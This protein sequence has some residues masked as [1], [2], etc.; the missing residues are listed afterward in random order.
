MERSPYSSTAARTPENLHRLYTLF[1]PLNRGV[2]L[3]FEVAVWGMFCSSFLARTTKLSSRQARRGVFAAKFSRKHCEGLLVKKRLPCVHQSTYYH[4]I[5]RHSTSI[6]TTAP[7]PLTYTTP[8]HL[9]RSHTLHYRYYSTYTAHMHHVQA[10]VLFW[11]GR[12][13]LF[14]GFA[15]VEA[16]SLWRHVFGR[17]Q[18][19]RVERP[20]KSV[21]NR[22]RRLHRLPHK[23]YTAHIHQDTYTAH[24]C[25]TAT[26]PRLYFN[27]PHTAQH[28][29]RAT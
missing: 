2:W 23:T 17:W 28:L 26:T 13:H 12:M 10:C 9:H 18:R 14:A 11:V 4:A 7:T 1:V 24:V 6:Y 22:R 20:A 3:H 29:H 27:R 16:L 21:W 5:P 25:T 19:W 8:Q 15:H